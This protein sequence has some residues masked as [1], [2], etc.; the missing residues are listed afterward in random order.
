M[1]ET[2]YPDGPAVSKQSFNLTY[3]LAQQIS[4]ITRNGVVD[5]APVLMPVNFSG[6]SEFLDTK[7]ELI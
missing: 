4:N 6:G 1:V 7:V 5:T 2:R 3:T